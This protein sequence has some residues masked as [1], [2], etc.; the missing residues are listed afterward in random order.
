ML[1][2]TAAAAQPTRMTAYMK[3]FEVY[4]MQYDSPAPSGTSVLSAS[5]TPCLHL[6][7]SGDFS[8]A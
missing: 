3:L 6:A 4:H 1:R 5:Q 8:L 2:R 7:A